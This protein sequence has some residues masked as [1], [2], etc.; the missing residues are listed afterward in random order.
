MIL[1]LCFRFV[2]DMKCLMNIHVYESS[3]QSE[4][5]KKYKQIKRVF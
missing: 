2:I 1:N 4:A 5:Q 3:G